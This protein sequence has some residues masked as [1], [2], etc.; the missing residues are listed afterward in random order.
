MDGYAEPRA[1]A[2]RAIESIGATPVMFERFGGRDSDPEAA[3]LAEVESSDIYVGLLGDRYGRPL[4]S[5]YSATHAEYR[6]AEE[7][8]LRLSVWS[9]TGGRRE[10]PQQSFLEEVRSFNV[11]G[12]FAT[13]DELET[14]LRT[15]LSTVA[16]EE[17]SPW[18]KVGPTIFRTKEIRVGG[19]RA[20]IKAVIRDADVADYLA[21]LDDRFG[22]RN[23][24]IAYWDGIYDARLT[25][26]PPSRVRADRGRSSS[27]LRS[28]NR[29][30]R[31]STGSM[32][33]ATQRQPRSRSKCLGLVSRIHSDRWVRWSRLEIRFPTWRASGSRRST[34][35]HSPSCSPT[36]RWR[37]KG[38]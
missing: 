11:T 26:F 12:E 17:L 28:P 36:R 33:S 27:S 34:T 32:G 29:S 3:Y 2:A 22:R 18:V 30:N 24:M 10:G 6:H 37:A 1:A 35:D 21:S 14:S 19:G 25:S 9:E 38:T 23:T 16:S 8:G 5:R 13:P 7:H 4:S 20:E 15:R 31:P